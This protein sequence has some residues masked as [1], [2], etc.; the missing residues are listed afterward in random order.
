MYASESE[1]HWITAESE[2]KC[3]CG[4]K[5]RKGERIYYLPAT[6]TALCTSCS[7]KTE[8]EFKKL[9]EDENFKNFWNR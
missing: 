1:P 3:T 6:R 9:M 5:I 8:E 4:N 2:L 7:E